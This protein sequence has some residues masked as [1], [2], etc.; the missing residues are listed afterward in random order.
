MASER[1]TLASVVARLER[2]LER[3]TGTTLD[4][5][6][7]RTVGRLIYAM[8]SGA[9]GTAT[10]REVC[11]ICGR[12]EHKTQTVGEYARHEYQAAILIPISPPDTE[13]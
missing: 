9:L 11:A 2:A 13:E 8:G 7:V 5:D 12:P 10:G 4:P 1:E 3:G 6:E